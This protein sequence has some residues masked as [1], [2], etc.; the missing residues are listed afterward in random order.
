M[1]VINEKR[2]SNGAIYY[3]RVYK[4]SKNKVIGTE[5]IV[6]PTYTRD[7][8]NGYK[9]II[10]YTSD[11]QPIPEAFDFLNQK[12]EPYST[13]RQAAP[14]LRLLYSYEVIIG[15]KLVDFT[16][17]DIEAF[18]DFLMGISY[19][20]ESIQ[21]NLFETRDNSTVNTYLGIY[22]KYCEH[23]G[24]EN[25]ALNQRVIRSQNVISGNFSDIN[26][27]YRRNER[28]VQSREVP[29]YIS[30]D[31]YK[32]ILDIIK[33]DYTIRE[34]II[35]RLMYEHGLRIGE[36]FGLT[37]DDVV[38]EN[39]EGTGWTN[40]IYLRNR[41][42]DDKVSQAAKGCMK[43]QTPQDYK[44][45]EYSIPDYGFQKVSITRDL[46]ELINEY[47]EEAHLAARVKY[48]KEYWD[49]VTAD[50]VRESEKY[51]D[52]NF[53]IFLNTRG[54]CLY[55]QTWNKTLRPIFIAA[56][57]ALDTEER[58]H[59]LNHRFRH[60]FAMRLVKKGIKRLELQILL[61]HKSIDSVACYFRP[62]TS[63]IIRIKELYEGEL[64]A[65]I[66]D[67]SVT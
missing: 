38:E 46:A 48:G 28:V 55:Q 24:I 50:R 16:I 21:F 67:L 42:S 14:A 3:E 22:R 54:G 29:R 1:Q 6:F 25:H 9:A 17:A 56:G 2:N 64:H 62:T 7:L 13:R 26:A 18:K 53:Y 45:K 33:K 44:R 27:P 61:R 23:I 37:N 60:G 59:N 30:E 11:M 51:E 20:G 58:E 36:V 47:I 63:D 41:C 43:V 12:R 35:V 34:E 57:I 5:D 4:D 65:D 10:M 49:R 31:E 15:K 8:K 66:P 19:G 39:I 52:P 32:R 40:V